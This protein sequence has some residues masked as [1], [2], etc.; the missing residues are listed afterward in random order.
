MKSHPDYS[1]EDIGHEL[2]LSTKEVINALKILSKIASKRIKKQRT[3]SAIGSLNHNGKG[4]SLNINSQDINEKCQKI[5]EAIRKD[6]R[7]SEIDISRQLHLTL[8]DVKSVLDKLSREGK[9]IIL[10]RKERR[11]RFIDPF[12]AR[13]KK[14][15]SKKPKHFGRR[16]LTEH[17][18]S[19]VRIGPTS[20]RH[21]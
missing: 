18:R 16:P 6:P 21:S 9:L 10:S 19:A 17:G 2:G 20:P 12:A 1:I 8:T 3:W 15:K 4:S 7:I 14:R 5:F 13:R 11:R